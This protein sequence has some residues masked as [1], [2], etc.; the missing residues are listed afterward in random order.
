M[1]RS[2]CGWPSGGE[3]QLKFYSVIKLTPAQTWCSTQW[4]PAGVGGGR[5]PVHGQGGQRRGRP[6]AGELQLGRGPPG[7]AG[8]Q[9][10][11]EH[12][13]PGR[14]HLAPGCRLPARPLH[15]ARQLACTARSAQPLP[16]ISVASSSASACLARNQQPPS[17]TTPAPCEICLHSPMPCTHRSERSTLATSGPPRAAVQALSPARPAAGAV[18]GRAAPDAA[19]LQAGPGRPAGHR[20]QGAPAPAPAQ[21]CP[22]LPAAEAQPGQQG[23]LAGRLR[24]CKSGTVAG[25]C[26][27]PATPAPRLPDAGCSRANRLARLTRPLS[28]AMTQAE[29]CVCPASCRHSIPGVRCQGRAAASTSLLGS[30]SP[31][32]LSWL[33]CFILGGR[34]SAQALPRSQCPAE[35]ATAG[36]HASRMAATHRSRQHLARRV[37]PLGLPKSKRPFAS[38][39]SVGSLHAGLPGA[40]P[41]S[42]N[43]FPL[44]WPPFAPCPGLSLWS[45]TNGQASG[46]SCPLAVEDIEDTCGRA[47]RRP[48]VP[49]SGH[50]QGSLCLG[51]GGAWCSVGCC[52]AG[53]HCSWAGAVRQPS[54]AHPA[55]PSPP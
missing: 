42:S 52:C 9:P 49:H 13:W 28:A 5:V 39:L 11:E 8:A 26:G 30:G 47:E 36:A 34:P 27:Q 43:A 23:R 20:V 1:A 46:L 4:L 22:P 48:S 15:G 29:T 50:A 35:A 41:D 16:L 19:G 51:K 7:G 18:G 12:P 33:V 44:K 25:C 32:V 3:L 45:T 6:A 53:R 10:P 17:C 54:P 14:A 37:I 40:A 38:P 2:L 55:Q 24:R 21:L 31:G